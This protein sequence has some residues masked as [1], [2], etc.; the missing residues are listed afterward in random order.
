MPIAAKWQ[1]YAKIIEIDSMV[2]S[3][4]AQKSNEKGNTHK[5]N[6]G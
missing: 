2:E 6:A 1:C 3:E 5:E 4:S